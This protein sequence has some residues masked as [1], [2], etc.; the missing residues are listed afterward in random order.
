M[1]EITQAVGAPLERPVRVSPLNLS[2]LLADWH[3]NEK[4]NTKTD[5]KRK[6]AR[7][8]IHWACPVC[9]E[10]FDED[11]E[12]EAEA[13]CQGKAADN[14]EAACPV[15]KQN[16]INHREAANCCLWKDID[17][18]TRYRMADAVECGSSWAAELG[19]QPNV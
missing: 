18:V 15:C 3:G 7:E 8:V 9:G 10:T 6:S 13:C 16:Y 11:E 1:S 17:A 2:G 4:P 5:K 19:L 12:K 14:E